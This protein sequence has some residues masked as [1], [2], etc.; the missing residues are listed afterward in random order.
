MDSID[1]VSEEVTEVTEETAAHGET[2]E[3]RTTDVTFGVVPGDCRPRVG[4]VVLRF[5]VS[6]CEAV[7]PWSP[8]LRVTS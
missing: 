8:F 3:R 2:G 7:T 1:G 6:P 5:T 4:T